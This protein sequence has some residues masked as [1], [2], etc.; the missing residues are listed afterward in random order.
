MHENVKNGYQ[1][2]II[3]ALKGTPITFL[4]KNLYSH[5]KRSTF[6]V[7]REMVSYSSLVNSQLRLLHF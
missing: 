2:L 5:S 6:N 1:N 3:G 4:D 7:T